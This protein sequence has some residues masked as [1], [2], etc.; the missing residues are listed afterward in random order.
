LA[1]IMKDDYDSDD[2][3]AMAKGHLFFAATESR[4]IRKRLLSVSGRSD[5]PVVDH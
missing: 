3:F 5:V 4:A 1:G 2:L